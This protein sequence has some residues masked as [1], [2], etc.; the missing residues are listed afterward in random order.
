MKKSSLISAMNAKRSM[1]IRLEMTLDS[2]HPDFH[3]KI[4]V[5]LLLYFRRVASP[6]KFNI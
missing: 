1:K 2:G 6:S 3:T 4:S 5:S